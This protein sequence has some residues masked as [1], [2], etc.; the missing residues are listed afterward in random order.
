MLKVSH[1]S[2]S[3]KNQKLPRSLYTVTNELK[4]IS[5][6]TKDEKLIVIMQ[7]SLNFSH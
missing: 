1:D 5:Q 2:L 4:T 7:N 6:Q 3:K